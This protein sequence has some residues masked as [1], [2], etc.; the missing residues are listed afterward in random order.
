M[1][2]KKER[3]LLMAQTMAFVQSVA[4]KTADADRKLETRLPSVSPVQPP[5]V[6]RPADIR[7][8]ARL[9]P[10]SHV[11][12]I[13]HGDLRDEIGRR[14]AAFRARQQIFHRDRD[15]YCNAMM[16]KVRAATEPAVKGRDNPPPKR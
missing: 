11:S 1:T 2:W 15:E 10:I 7:P 3:D 5:T 9:S 14:V 16:A 13:S 8:V 12:P 6:E 4:G